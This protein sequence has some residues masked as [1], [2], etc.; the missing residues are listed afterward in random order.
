MGAFADAIAKLPAAPPVRARIEPHEFVATWESRPADAIVVGLR[1]VPA[2]DES[3]ARAE[4]VRVTRESI[5]PDAPADV[6]TDAYNDALVGWVVARGICDPNDATRTHPLFQ[7]PEDQVP[8]ALS[9]ATLR[10]L[11]DEIERA[12]VL[13]SPCYGEATDDEIAT[14]AG[15]LLTLDHDALPPVER[16]RVRRYLRFVLDE[17]T[18]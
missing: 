15:R 3:A 8:D 12:T 2:R 13:S 10:R 9:S 1:L 16:A 17:M 11:Y 5:G 14:L 18:T 7:M 6:L 4:A